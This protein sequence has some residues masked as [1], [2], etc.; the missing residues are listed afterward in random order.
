MYNSIDKIKKLQSEMEKRIQKRRTQRTRRT[1]RRKDD[2]NKLTEQIGGMYI[3]KKRK[4]T[5]NNNNRKRTV[6]RM[7]LTKT[8]FTYNSNTGL[9]RFKLVPKVIDNLKVIFDKSD[10]ERKE[11]AFGISVQSMGGRRLPYLDYTK[12]DYDTS[13][14]RAAIYSDII[15][16]FKSEY[17]VGHTHPS[18]HVAGIRK[19]TPGGYYFTIPS[20]ADFRAFQ[21]VFGINGNEKSQA[22]LILDQHGFYIISVIESKRVSQN[23]SPEQLY[24]SMNKYLSSLEFV[25]ERGL[26]DPPLQYFKCPTIK[27]WSD[28]VNFFGLNL[29]NKTGI[30]LQYHPWESRSIK[31]S[32]LKLNTPVITLR[33]K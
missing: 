32:L 15:D 6:K 14:Q 29:F 8:E 12:Y 25:S 5:I 30:K 26:E 27:E 4:R 18:P 22:Q 19:N 13:N 16:K 11:Y 28:S 2:V 3:T 10:N 20:I 1:L 23:Y 17:I 31:G 24:S 7:L 9:V 21:S 33:I